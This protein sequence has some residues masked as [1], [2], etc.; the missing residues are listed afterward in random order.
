MSD[1]DSLHVTL[2]GPV[3]GLFATLVLWAGIIA[4]IV[5]VVVTKGI[6]FLY[7]LLVLFLASVGYIAWVATHCFYLW[8]ARGFKPDPKGWF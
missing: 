7:G 8:A 4:F 2:N 6:A 5:S 3:F 1:Q